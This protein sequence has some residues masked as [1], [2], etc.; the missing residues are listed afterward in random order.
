MDYDLVNYILDGHEVVPEPN[1]LKWAEWYEH[2]DRTVRQT[3]TERFMVSTVFLGIDTGWGKGPPI[4]FETMVFTRGDD[5]TPDQIDEQWRYATWS[6]A[7]AGHAATLKRVIKWE[8]ENPV[9]EEVT[10]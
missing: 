2:A 6:D 4:C 9:V 7:E 1:L 3:H 8:Q 5:A 10:E